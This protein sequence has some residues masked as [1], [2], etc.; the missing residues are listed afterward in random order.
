VI[1]ILP[2][3]SQQKAPA[4]EPQGLFLAWRLAR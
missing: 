3:A 4:A 2:E 1:S